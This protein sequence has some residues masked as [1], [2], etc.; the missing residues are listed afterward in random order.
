MPR[1]CIQWL[2]WADL[3]IYTF[4]M[5]FQAPYPLL[6]NYGFGAARSGFLDLYLLALF[7]ASERNLDQFKDLG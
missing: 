6:P 2:A 5:T 4:F 1:V 3:L 7:N